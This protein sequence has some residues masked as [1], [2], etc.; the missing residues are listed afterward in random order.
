MSSCPLP[1]QA[2]VSDTP[3]GHVADMQREEIERTCGLDLARCNVCTIVTALD[4]FDLKRL[5]KMGHRFETWPDSVRA[6]ME[7]ELK[8]F[9]ERNGG[10]QIVAITQ[11]IGG[12]PKCFILCLHWRPR[13]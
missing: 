8:G 11:A 5:D 4:E 2:K 12:E 13:A 7:R 3:F 9:S 10:A 1:A 6:I